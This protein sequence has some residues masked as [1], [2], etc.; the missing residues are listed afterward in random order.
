MSLVTQQYYVV[1]GVLW[2]THPVKGYDTYSRK[3]YMPS[4]NVRCNNCR[5]DVG[6]ATS[7]PLVAPQSF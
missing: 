2:S 5:E 7:S 3:N 4:D 6:G 1:I